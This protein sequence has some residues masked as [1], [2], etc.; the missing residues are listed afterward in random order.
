MSDDGP[1]IP[2]SEREAVFQRFYRLDSSRSSTGSGLGLSL[3]AAVAGLH[4]I[5]VALEDNQ[6]GLKAV[7]RWPA[8]VEE[9]SD[10]SS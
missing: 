6:P 5:D 1:G 4:G 7:L 2:A 3:V 8:A 9:N 10:Q